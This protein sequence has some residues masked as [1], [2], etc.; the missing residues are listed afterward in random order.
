[1]PGPELNHS[2]PSSAYVKNEWSSTSVSPISFRVVDSE[3]FTL[4]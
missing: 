4:I 1:L 3:K 2:L